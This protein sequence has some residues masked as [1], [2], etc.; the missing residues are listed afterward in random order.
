M[1]IVRRPSVTLL[2][3][4]LLLSGGAC[5]DSTAPD[6]TPLSADESRDLAVQIGALFSQGLAGGV[7]ASRAADASLSVIPVPFGF[8]VENLRVPCPEGGATTVTASVNGTVDN[9]TQSITATLSGTNEPTACGV[10][11]H[12]KT[13]FITGK[14]KSN[15]R[16][17]VV[18]GLPDGENTASLIGE[19]DWRS[20]NGRRSGHC[21]VNYVA[22]A[23]YAR[24]GNR[25]EVTGD[26]CGT[27]MTFSGPITT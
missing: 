14:F 27:R 21:V 2:V 13:F 23:I 12:G 1:P 18:N 17:H 24:D 8:S 20:A 16:V 26:F 11:A 6:T 7:V 5:S 25:A 4:A 9:A 19:F 10:R 15:A 22:K 3:G